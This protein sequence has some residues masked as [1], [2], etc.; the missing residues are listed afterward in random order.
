VHAFRARVLFIGK[1]VIQEASM[2]QE[3]AGDGQERNRASGIE[4]SSRSRGFRELGYAR[5]PLGQLVDELFGSSFGSSSG[6]SQGLWPVVD[7]DEDDEAYCVCLEVPGVSREDLHVEIQQDQVTVRGEKRRS[8]S[9]GRARWNERQYGSF[10]RAFTLPSD[11]DPERAR[12]AFENG[13]LT[14]TFPKREEAK[15][16]RIE[17]E[18]S[19][20]RGQ[21]KSS[22]S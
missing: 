16:R 7:V 10:T 20:E 19:S 9:G 11:A 2:Q 12:A 13:V 22:R 1:G 18:A 5:H 4:Q 21:E 15:A 6:G 3:R 14:L 17:I 8:E